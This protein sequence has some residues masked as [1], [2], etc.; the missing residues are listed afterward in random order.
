L[1]PFLVKIA[2]KLD[3][4]SVKLDSNPQLGF[5][6]RVTLKEEKNI[7]KCKSISVIDATKGSGVRFSD[8]DLADI[9]ERYQVLNSIYRTAQ[10]DL[11]RKVIATCG[12]KT[13]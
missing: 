8:G 12:S 9:N 3:I 13:G 5:F 10:Q 11:E 2:K 4:E 7:R 6:Y 1:L